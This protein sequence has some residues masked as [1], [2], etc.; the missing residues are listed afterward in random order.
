MKFSSYIHE[1]YILVGKTGIDKKLGV[2]VC[3]HVCIHAKMC[4]RVLYIR[5]ENSYTCGCIY[6]C[7]DVMP[8]GKYCRKKESREIGIGNV[9]TGLEQVAI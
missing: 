1:A 8:A 9:E 7:V 5:V 4:A 3:I 6:F 2:G